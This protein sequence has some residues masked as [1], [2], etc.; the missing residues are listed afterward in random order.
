MSDADEANSGGDRGSAGRFITFE[1]PE[2][3]GKTT[4]MRVVAQRLREGGRAVV[5]TREPGG[6]RAGERVRAV[7]LDRD[8]GGLQP[9]AE[10]LLFGAARGT[11]PCCGQEQSLGLTGTPYRLPRELKCHACRQILILEAE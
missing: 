10:A 8:S 6:T 11:C 3:A 4:V 2:G 1:G 9:T 5:E 7:L